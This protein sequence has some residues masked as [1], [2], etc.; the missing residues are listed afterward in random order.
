MRSW[1]D[2][3]RPSCGE[4]T[5]EGNRLVDQRTIANEKSKENLAAGREMLIDL[6]KKL[7]EGDQGTSQVQARFSTPGQRHQEK[8][9]VQNSG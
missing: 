5:S 2:K 7:K 6:Q 1:L 9:L 8:N 3:R 4:I